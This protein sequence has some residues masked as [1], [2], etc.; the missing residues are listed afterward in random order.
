MSAMAKTSGGF[1]ATVLAGWVLLSVIG[2][3]FARFKG[4]PTWAALPALAAFLIEYPFY[5]VP[6]FRSVREELAGRALPWYLVTSAVLPYLAASMGATHFAWINLLKLIAL[7]LV[8]WLW[9]RILPVAPVVDIGFLALVVAVKLSGVLEPI[10]L[11]TYKGLE[12]ARMGDI[13][14]LQI[15]VMVLILERRV[16]ETGYWFLPSA[17]DW[18]IGA[19]H[20]LYYLPIGF[21]LA[22]GLKAVR[23]VPPHDVAKVAASF[24]MWLFVLTLAEE[25]IFRG[26]L[27]QWIEDWTRSQQVALIVTSVLFGAVHLWFGKQFPNWK[28]MIV[29]GALGWFCGRARNQ[30]GNIRA[31]MVTHSLVIA[32]WR[33]FFV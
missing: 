13:A 15:A 32:T 22:L 4:I 8:P 3:W 10:Y 23:L 17:K 31:S 33:L 9:Y 1:R 16:A 12:I 6:A 20:Y 18:R 24:V 14:L 29:A 19:L 25:F 7:A 2:L 21:G 28:W 30:A 11:T 26:V 5:L 27:Q